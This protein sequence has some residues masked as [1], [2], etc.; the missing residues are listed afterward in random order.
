MMRVSYT[1]EGVTTVFDTDKEPAEVLEAVRARMFPDVQ[2]LAV[3][4]KFDAIMVER[5]K[6]VAR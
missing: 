4:A 2:V 6:E 5:K 3:D 1:L